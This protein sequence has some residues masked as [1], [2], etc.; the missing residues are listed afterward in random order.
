MRGKRTPSS[1]MSQVRDLSAVLATRAHR[2]KWLLVRVMAE[3]HVSTARHG[4]P[5]FVADDDL[6][7]P[8]LLRKDRAPTSTNG[9]K[10]TP[11]NSE[12]LTSTLRTCV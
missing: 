1:A 5:E 9:C 7:N 8:P 11:L 2:N 10:I 3:S 6:L 4:A 12:N